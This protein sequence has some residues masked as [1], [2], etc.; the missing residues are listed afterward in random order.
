[1]DTA[2]A[3]RTIV[4]KDGTAFLQ[5]GA[6]IVADS[7]PDKEHEECLAKMGALIKALEYAKNSEISE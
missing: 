5:A 1:M 4:L 3:I 2:I 6:G 7:N